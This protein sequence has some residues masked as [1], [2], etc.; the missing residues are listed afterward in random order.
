MGKARRTAGRK[1]REGGVEMRRCGLAVVIAVVAAL[2]QMPVCRAAPLEGAEALG[3]EKFTVHLEGLLT[4]VLEKL[5][6]LTKKRILLE[7]AEEV[8]PRAKPGGPAPVGAEPPVG[9]GPPVG[10]KPPGPKPAGKGVVPV[11]LDFENATLAE[12]LTSVCEQAGVI[13]EVEGARV[14]R[15]REGDPN[16]D[17]RPTADLGDYVLHITEV[18]IS[19]ERK[20]TLERGTPLA[21]APEVSGS[22]GL[23]LAISS[24]S[25]QADLL[26]AGIGSDYKATT[27][28]GGTLKPE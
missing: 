3:N 20:Y 13:G 23:S 17:P 27:D 6:K 2:A 9:G 8:G 11:K 4:D 25:A 10:G 22:L 12:I 14:V 7:D 16:I 28:M 21:D 1:A 19:S 5:S 15:L 24:K 18:G 26:L